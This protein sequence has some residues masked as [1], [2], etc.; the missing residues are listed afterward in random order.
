MIL[1]PDLISFV[2]EHEDDDIHSLA[3]NAKK[4]SGIDIQLA[5]RQIS[6]RR[7]AKDKIPSWYIIDRILYPKHLS[8]EQSSS[9]KT[10]T[11]KASLVSGISMIDLTGGIGV[12]FS[13]LSKQFIHAVYVEQQLELSEIARYNFAVLGLEN[14]DVVNAK[15]EEYLRSL[16][17]VDL[18][19]IDPARRNDAGRKTVRIEDCT[20]DVL[21]IQDLL[22]EK[23]KMVMIKLSPMLDISL[24]LNS[25]RN[26]SDVHIVSVNNEVKELLFIKQK[27]G[28]KITFYCI[29]IK[30]DK[31][32]IYSFGRED[33]DNTA[34]H[35]TS[36]LGAYLYEPN[37]SILKAGAYKSIARSY[38]LE[39]LHPNSHL[40][41]SD[42]LK[43][44][45]PGRKFAVRNICSLNKKD[46]KEY[47]SPFK[48]ANITVR[49]FPLTVEEIRKK[50][51]LK[52]G[53]N[54]YIFATTLS[55][56]KKVLIICE[57]I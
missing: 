46:I 38:S 5:I 32:E 56:D 36:Q 44:N 52:D 29:N 24:A 2:K 39:K 51:N 12:D 54:V 8:L 19:Y 35:Y 27:N 4:Y 16:P 6:G 48:Q 9:E 23:S 41:T 20:P 17:P 37:A 25:L 53:G 34:I 13:F 15:A 57:K 7:I 18:I 26:I 22:E 47:L 3:L 50:T 31:T 21:D 1:S 45:F 42:G 33:E 49:N 43:E 10:A 28:G 30:K 14:I 11:Y 40:Y 55:G